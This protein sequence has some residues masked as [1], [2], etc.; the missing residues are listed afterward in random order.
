M[1]SD[2]RRAGFG[3]PPFEELINTFNARGMPSFSGVSFR[4]LFP[5]WQLDAFICNLC[6]KN[7]LCICSVVLYGC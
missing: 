3:E 6:E 5:T 4:S 2:K 7:C 1:L